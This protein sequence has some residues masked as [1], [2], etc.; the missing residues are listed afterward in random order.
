MAL[1]V[2][3]AADTVLASEDLALPPNGSVAVVDSLI[4]PLC[5][6][7]KCYLEQICEPGAGSGSGSQIMLVDSPMHTG[8]PSEPSIRLNSVI[9]NLEQISN[10]VG[11]RWAGV[12]ARFLKGKRGVYYDLGRS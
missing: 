11:I 8:R 5:L 6:A 12:I 10:T 9:T 7:G 2:C 4:L 3:V 1:D